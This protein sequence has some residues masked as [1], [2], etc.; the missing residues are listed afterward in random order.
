MKLDQKGGIALALGGGGVTGCCHAGVVRALEEEGIP[1]QAVAGTSAGALAAAMLACGGTARELAELT[2]RL[3]AKLMDVDYAGLAC[4]WFAPKGS[5]P[6]LIRGRRLVKL[7]EEML[8]S[9]RISDLQ[10]PFAVAATDL[11]AGSQVLFANRPAESGILGPHCEV[12]PDGD[13]VHAVMASMSIPGIFRPVRMGERLLVDGG[14]MDNCPAAALKAMGA[15]RIVAVDLVTVKPMR[16]SKWSFSS[17]LSRSVS[18][19]LHRMSQADSGYPQLILSPELGS[20]GILDF[21]C[22]GRCMELGYECAKA[23]M[24]HIRKVAEGG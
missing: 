3:S 6:G 8:G 20:I 5:L 18:L 1:V 19:G 7:L 23:N 17:I 10:L 16:P 14:L 4:R 11:A 9:R 13:L 15:T 24:P 22:A 2:S 12:V 21:P